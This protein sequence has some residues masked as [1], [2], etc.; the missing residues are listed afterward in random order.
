[1][2]Y[3]LSTTLL[4]IML[5]TTSFAQNT[6]KADLAHS[7][8]DFTVNH[9]VV[10]EVSG[11]FTDFDV[12]L[13]QGKDDFSG[14]AIDAT[15]KTASINTDNSQRDGHLRSDDFLNAEK[16]PV[17]KFE[18][19]SFEKT[20]DNTF[21]I[22]GNLTIRDVTKPVVLSATLN[23]TVKTPWG[24]ERAGFVATTSI[25]RFD[26]GVKW[27]KALDTGGLIAGKEVRITLRTELVK[28]KP[29]GS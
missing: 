23:G 15:I 7:R 27:D 5:M 18:S 28:Q 26:Y 10:S 13:R 22:T 17:M 16:F 12:T 25:N 19:T 21:T 3:L 2:K 4:A 8:V 11:R 9:L 29:A 20:G 24:D 14:S 6:W 1:M